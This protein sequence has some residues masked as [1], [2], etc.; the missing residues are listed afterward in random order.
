M[1][2]WSRP[3]RP[4]PVLR[5]GD[6]R[7]PSFLPRSVSN[8]AGCFFYTSTQLFTQ[9][10]Q[11]EWNICGGSWRRKTSSLFL[12]A[13]SSSESSTLLSFWGEVLEFNNL[14]WHRHVCFTSRWRSCACLKNISLTNFNQT[15]LIFLMQTCNLCSWTLLK[16]VSR[17]ALS[18]TI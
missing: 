1:A 2:A 18:K 9:K 6:E 14:I 3:R 8:S 16:L 17:S 15:I 10:P 11:R 13:F 4:R 5:H 12:S 7:W